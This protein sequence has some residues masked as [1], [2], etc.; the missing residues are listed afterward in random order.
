[1]QVSWHGADHGWGGGGMGHI[2]EGTRVRVDPAAVAQLQVSDGAPSF[3]LEVPDS[4]PGFNPK[5]THY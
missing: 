4:I 1:M 2:E 5:A 3:H